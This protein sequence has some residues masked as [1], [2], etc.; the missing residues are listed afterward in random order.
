MS[1]LTNT[2]HRSIQAESFSQNFYHVCPIPAPQM[3]SGAL[4]RGQARHV[5]RRGSFCVV[6]LWSRFLPWLV[7]GILR[8]RGWLFYDIA[9]RYLDAWEQQAFTVP[10]SM[11]SE[12][13]LSWQNFTWDD[14]W[15]KHKV[16][17]WT[18][19]RA[20]GQES[21]ILMLWASFLPKTTRDLE[22]CDLWREGYSDFKVRN[23]ILFMVTITT[24]AQNHP[25]VEFQTKNRRNKTK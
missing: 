16:L 22:Y 3:G 17:D 20:R 11:R 15:Q 24:H 9:P 25:K 1:K 12:Y 23:K 10:D 2:L 4:H 8:I 6:R 13:G 14:R 19:T 18:F 5:C 7:S 21:S